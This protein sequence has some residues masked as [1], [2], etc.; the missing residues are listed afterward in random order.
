MGPELSLLVIGMEKEAPTRGNA[1]CH[2]QDRVTRMA[3]DMGW[4]EQDRVQ[5]DHKVLKL[6][7][8]PS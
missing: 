1:F 2:D 8:N 7:R 5:E 6:N 4:R 3:L